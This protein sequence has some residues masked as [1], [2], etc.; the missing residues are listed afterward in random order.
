MGYDL[1]RKVTNLSRMQKDPVCGM[2]I[3]PRKT[4]LHSVYKSEHY[5]FCSKEC[6]KMFDADS[7][8]YIF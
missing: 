8:K 6:K 3:D 1:L 5:L 7:E 2:K 4:Q